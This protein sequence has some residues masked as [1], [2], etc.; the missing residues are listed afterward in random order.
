MMNKA[1]SAAR[2]ITGCCLL[3]AAAAP[4][5]QHPRDL[6]QPV[7]ISE[8]PAVLTELPV[9]YSPPLIPESGQS[10]TF[11]LQYAD[12]ADMLALL[13]QHH[14]EWFTDNKAPEADPLTN[15]L[16]IEAQPDVLSRAEAWLAQM[17][18]PQQQVQITAH[19]VSGSREGLHELGLQWGTVLPS[20]ESGN[21]LQLHQA[22]GNNTFTFNIARLG[23]HLLEMELSALE[24]EQQLDIVASPRLT[25][26]HEHPASI[27]QG[28]EIPYTTQ[29]HE[30]G[31]RV[32]FREAVLGMEVTPQ[33]LRD[34]K[35]RLTLHISRNAPGA[36]LM[37]NGS[38]QYSIDK[39]EITTQ[40]IVRSGETLIL[41]GIFQ[42]DKGRQVTGVPYLSSIP[43]M[44]KLFT[45]QYDK[46]SRR[47]LVIFITP[48]LIDI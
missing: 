14:G 27:K 29:N 19:I 13:K 7:V 6:F 28:A 15:S 8:E 4:G 47:E 25:T 17:D 26:A 33:I 46:L 21:R 31:S 10:R 18:Q 9:M 1:K 20:P 12:A 16:L 42:Q 35:V 34:N 37:Q 48:Q 38:E 5:G 30:S 24:Q 22:R 11:T 32:Q 39:Q 3:L 41:G 36:A 40:V 44:G 23:G 43:L 2:L 45:H